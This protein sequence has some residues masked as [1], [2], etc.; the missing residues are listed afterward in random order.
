[1]NEILPAFL[2]KTTPIAIAISVILKIFGKIFDG[3]IFL[4]IRVQ[5]NADLK[6]HLR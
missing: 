5:L 2:Q 1:M 4:L 3:I 6:I